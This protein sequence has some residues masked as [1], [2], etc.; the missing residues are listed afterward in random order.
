MKRAIR[1]I[2]AIL[3]N[4]GFDAGK[5]DGELGKKTVVAIKAFQKTVGQEPTGQIDDALV[6][7]LLKHNKKA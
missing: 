6:K 2:Q 3:N 7:E 1:N 4:N 5:P